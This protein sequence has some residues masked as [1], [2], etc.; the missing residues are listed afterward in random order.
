LLLF[1]LIQLRIVI[2][3]VVEMQE[4]AYQ[5]GTSC[6]TNSIAQSKS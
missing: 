1:F 5:A 3:L 4:V 2:T 6:K